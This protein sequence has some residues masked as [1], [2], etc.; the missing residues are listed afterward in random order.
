MIIVGERIN[1]SRRDVSQAVERRDKEFIQKLA[2]QQI[3]GGANWLDINAGTM[4]EKEPE[5]LR[6]LVKVVQEKEGNIP[7][8][9]DSPSP[10][11]I[12]AA[13]EEVKGESMINSI[14][15]EEDRFQALLPLVKKYNTSVVA[16]CMDAE[17]IPPT[18][19]KRLEVA[20]SL[21]Q[22]LREAEVPLEKIFVDPLVQSV[23]TEVRGGGIVLEVIERLRKEVDGIHT[24]IG[25]SNISYGLPA[26]RILN[27][28]FLVMTMAKGLDAVILDPLDLRLMS[29]LKASEALLG[30]DEM[31]L[32]YITA[33]RQKRL[34]A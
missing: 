28:A 14:T 6:W 33:Y 24:I 8:C 30:E 26:R 29:L 11:A 1:T 13:L 23:G 17:G 21:V 5:C 18:G 10:R 31:C 16:L 4:V 20:R 3:E 32:N 27:Q 34:V 7:L 19:E 12:Q 25:L 9:I 2:H 15:G 22:K